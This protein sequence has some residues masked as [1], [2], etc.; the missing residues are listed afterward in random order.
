MFIIKGFAIVRHSG[1]L[2]RQACSNSISS[3]PRQK[4]NCL[5][6]IDRPKNPVTC[7]VSASPRNCIIII[8]LS[9]KCHGH[10]LRPPESSTFS[11]PVSL[12]LCFFISLFSF[13]PP[14]LSSSPSQSLHLSLCQ[15][16][17]EGPP[18]GLPLTA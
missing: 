17:S 10:I 16:G 3:H 13:P 2:H 14:S 11:S 9:P 4:I 5:L 7:R 1:T 12:S 6:F 18:I 8:S 15:T